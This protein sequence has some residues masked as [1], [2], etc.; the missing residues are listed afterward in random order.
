MQN[1]DHVVD[2]VKHQDHVVDRVKHQDPDPLVDREKAQGPVHVVVQEKLPNHLAGRDMHQ[3][4][5]LGVLHERDH[6]HGHA[7]DHV[8]LRGHD[9]L[10]TQ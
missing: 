4:R 5:V 8:E 2:H 1:Q 7:V 10:M 9:H 6:V 3:D